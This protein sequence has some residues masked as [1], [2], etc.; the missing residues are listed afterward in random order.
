MKSIL[1]LALISVLGIGYLFQPENAL[2][3]PTTDTKSE[4]VDFL[5]F[6]VPGSE[7]EY[8]L[9][10][11]LS[12]EAQRTGLSYRESLADN[13]GMLFIFNELDNHGIWMKDM[14]FNLDI[15][16][17]DENKQIVYL[18]QAVT[19]ESFPDIFTPNKPAKYVIEMSSGFI[20]NEN[21]Q[22]GD[23]LVF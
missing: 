18:K 7:N 12:P 10:V 16:W 9:E 23:K 14:N 4:S 13:T 11:A 20:S 5:P 17:V 22:V 19:P 8:S 3:Q 21:L 6:N 1:L 15:L 2:D